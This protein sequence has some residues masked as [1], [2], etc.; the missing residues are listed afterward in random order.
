V[1]C[2]CS[3]FIGG[4][5]SGSVAAREGDGTKSVVNY[6][7]MIRK[8]KHA[9]DILLLGTMERVEHEDFI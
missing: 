8:K 4:S 9:L 5:E 3:K 7:V 1:V 2:G 6:E